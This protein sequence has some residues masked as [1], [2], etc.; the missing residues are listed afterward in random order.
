MKQ[1]RGDHDTGR[2]TAMG[3][4]MPFEFGAGWKARDSRSRPG[5]TW[6][7]GGNSLKAKRGCHWFANG[8][9]LSGANGQG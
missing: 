9:G 1:V 5:L 7:P 6:M 4:E 8:R 3:S 2:C